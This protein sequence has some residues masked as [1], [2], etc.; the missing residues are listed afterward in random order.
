MNLHLSLRLIATCIG[1][2]LCCGA[3]PTLHADTVVLKN[4]DRL[5]GTAIKLDG[6]KLTFKTAYSDPIVLVWDQVAN[7][8]YTAL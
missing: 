1:A 5:T 7:S 6:G 2:V 3:F 4:G 8:S